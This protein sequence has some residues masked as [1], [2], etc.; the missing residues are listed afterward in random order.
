MLKAA[1]IEDFLLIV[2]LMLAQKSWGFLLGDCLPPCSSAPAVEQC[3][4]L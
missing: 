2:I 4:K 1:Y 3:D